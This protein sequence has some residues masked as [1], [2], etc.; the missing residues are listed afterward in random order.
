MYILIGVCVCVSLLVI[1]CLCINEST[2]SYAVCMKYTM[3]LGMV[4]NWKRQVK[5]IL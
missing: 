2:C 5:L 3:F 4:K 1:E